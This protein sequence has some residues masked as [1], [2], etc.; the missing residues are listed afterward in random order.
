[1]ILN[2]IYHITRENLCLYL[3]YY[4]ERA[5][6][7][8]LSF[9]HPVGR[10]LTLPASVYTSISHTIATRQFPSMLF[11]KV[12]TFLSVCSVALAAPLLEARAVSRTSPPS[13]SLVVR[14]GST[15]QGEYS[16][17]SKAIS[18]LG[19]GTA[20]ASIFI[21]PGTYNEQVTI[22]YNG[23]LTLYG[24]TAEL[25]NTIFSRCCLIVWLTFLACYSVS[26]YKNNQVTVTQSIAS[27]KIGSLDLSSTIRAHGNNFAMYNINAR[28]N[29]GQGSPVRHLIIHFLHPLIFRRR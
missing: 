24:Y 2:S 6:V 17:I 14:Q 11:T 15:K 21:Y 1:M 23:P 9:A 7:Y 5:Y 25:V 27:L 28:N 18:A 10:S 8:K 20:S 3:F 26:N 29:Y 12:F 16:T 19:K 13:G 22:D 4:D